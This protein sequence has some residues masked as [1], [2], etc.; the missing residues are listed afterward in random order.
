[1]QQAE[2]REFEHARSLSAHARTSHHRCPAWGYLVPIR[3][4]LNH[5]YQID[6]S[7][8]YIAKIYALR[9]VP[10]PAFIEL[11]ANGGRRGPGLG[12]YALPS[13]PV[14]DGTTAIGC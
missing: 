5:V 10:Q 4:D 6:V 8:R 12:G 3:G 11:F 9:A 1:M 13:Y 2:H 14:E 7:N